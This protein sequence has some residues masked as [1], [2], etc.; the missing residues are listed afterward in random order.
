MG[1]RSTS[2]SDSMPWIGR[3][4]RSELAID[5]QL[6]NF[7]STLNYCSCNFYYLLNKTDCKNSFLLVPSRWSTL[8]KNVQKPLCSWVKDNSSS[9]LESSTNPMATVDALSFSIPSDSPPAQ[10]NSQ[11]SKR[12][13]PQI[14]H[15]LRWGQ[16]MAAHIR[17]RCR[18]VFCPDT[19][20]TST[21]SACGDNYKEC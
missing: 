5:W 9:P 16:S 6:T 3:E 18:R 8:V 14:N 10:P 17:P 1:T 15:D 20:A 19:G 12:G 13:H 21:T 7:S 11:T 2:G 4:R